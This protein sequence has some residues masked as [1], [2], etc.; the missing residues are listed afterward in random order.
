MPAIP[1]EVWVAEECGEVVALLV[2]EAGWIDQLDVDPEHTAQG[3]GARRF[4]ERHG[5]VATGA[6]TGA[7]EEGAPD[8]RYEWRRPELGATPQRRVGGATCAGKRAG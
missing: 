2:L 8:I 5:F 6:T 4:Y 7:N 1:K 3:L